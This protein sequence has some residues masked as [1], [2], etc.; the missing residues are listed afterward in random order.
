MAKTPK[1]Y[2]E[3]FF[4]MGS[5][6]VILLVLMS[7]MWINNS[8]KLEKMEVSVAHNFREFKTYKEPRYLPSVEILDPNGEIINLKKTEGQYTVLNIWAT[9]CTPCVKELPALAELHNRLPFDS[10]WRVIA[11]S[12]DSPKNMSKVFSFTERLNIS[13]IANYSD[14]NLELQKIINV[15]KLP[16]TLI[17]NNKGRILYQIYGSAFWYDKEIIDFLNLIKKVY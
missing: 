3:K 12:I 7:V 4:L 9:W 17:I 5:F 10:K 11:V 6:V 14:Y 15:E 13:D 2:F 8:N 16:L 1:N